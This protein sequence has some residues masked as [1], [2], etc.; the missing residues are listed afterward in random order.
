MKA[1][2][3]GLWA[4][5][6][7][8]GVSNG[9]NNMEGSRERTNASM[10]GVDVN[11]G[12]DISIET[13]VVGAAANGQG[14]VG[15]VAD[16]RRGLVSLAAPAKYPY[17]EHLGLR[18]LPRNALL[19]SLQFYMQ[20]NSFQVGK[21]QDGSDYNHYTVFPKSI[22]P[23]MENTQTRQL[24]LRF[25][26]GLWDHENW[27]QLPHAGAKSG[28]SGVELWAVM[29]AGSRDEAFR[30][31]LLMTHSLSGLFCASI[32]FI[33]STKT[34][35]PVSS[36][37]PRTD[38][39]IPL[40]NGTNHLYLLRGSL[41]NEPVCT[42]NLTPFLKL[43][44]TRGRQGL[45]TLLE[46]HKVFGSR[47]HSLSLDVST[48]CSEEGL[49][50]YEMEEFIEL[51][52]DVPSTLARVERPI[53]KPLDG[54]NLRCDTSKHHDSW[55]CFPLSD[56]TS[57][58]IEL[59][60]L[61]GRY[62]MDAT[63]LSDTP[64]KA[65]VKVSDN[66]KVLIK[67]GDAYF[68]TATNCFDVKGKKWHDIYLD[69]D[70]T[71]KVYPV[72]SSPVFVTRS[73]TGYSQDKGGL[74]TVFRNPTDQPVSLVYFESLPWYMRL[75]LSTVKIETDDNLSIN[76]VIKSTYYLPARDRE[77]PT[78]LEYQMVIPAN[79][80]FALTYQ[81]DK[82]LLQYAEYPPDAN[83]GFEIESAVVT[84]LSPFKYEFRTATLLLSLSTPDFSMPYNVI[85]LTSTV[86]GL[87]FGT[88]FNMLVKKITTVEE[89]DKHMQHSGLRA[90]ARSIKQN[91]FDKLG[92]QKLKKD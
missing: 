59:S 2:I 12:S 69:T 31:W 24:H 17:M 29:E 38:E 46:G 50:H 54:S 28:G 79:T 1:S 84:V 86:M 41:A 22:T 26:H 40:L 77:R 43:L 90:R 63:E 87:I 48:I 35:F 85:I 92:S 72:D 5:S 18:P 7:L 33:D 82:S 13:A 9:L 44:P 14:A 66:W 20:S 89:A 37:Q 47:W 34:T 70:D 78:H 8:I 83:H 25:T 30:N 19:A 62:I 58:K 68:T 74:R 64:S 51:A 42:E 56:S 88:L 11:S 49:C 45:S 80:T 15:G 52:L 53:P 60:K 23:V 75:Y 91:L 55:T 27:G 3:I 61:F 67:A 39:R 16:E 36:F 32:N 71:T 73:L 76:D 65:C 4:L 81:F 10:S 21:Q 57:A 6:S